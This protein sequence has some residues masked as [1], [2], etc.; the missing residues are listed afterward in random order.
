MTLTLT[1]SGRCSPRTPTLTLP[2]GPNPNQIRALLASRALPLVG[3]VRYGGPPCESLALHAA[4][5]RL[6]HPMPAMA[7]LPLQL[8][9]D[10][11]EE[12]DTVRGW[13]WGWG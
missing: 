12:W 6:S 3:D 7:G 5:L 4:A 2:Y 10:V 13:G 8:T 9:A 1:R 11:P